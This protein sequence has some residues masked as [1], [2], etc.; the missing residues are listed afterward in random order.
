M[1]D[2]EEFESGLEELI[3]WECYQDEL[4]KIE[5]EY[6]EDYDE[7]EIE[8]WLGGDERQPK[9]FVSQLFLYSRNR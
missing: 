1:T 2:L 9:A 8:R 3:A 4:A 6:C 5:G 7:L